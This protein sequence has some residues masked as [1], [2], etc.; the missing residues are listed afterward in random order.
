[1]AENSLELGGKQNTNIFKVTF[2]RKLH[3]LREATEHVLLSPL[4]TGNKYN[5]II[6]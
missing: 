1:V 4:G 3:T 5:V 2:S 6:S